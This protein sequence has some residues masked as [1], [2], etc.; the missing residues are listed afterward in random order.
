M[1]DDCGN[2]RH[3]HFWSK[4]AA[5]E[6]LSLIERR[7][8]PEKAY[9]RESCR[10]LLGEKGLA[11]LRPRKVKQKYCNRNRRVRGSVAI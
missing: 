1:Y 2:G 8:M 11:G 9:Y 5:K 7:V 4:K 10:R 3:S 6:C